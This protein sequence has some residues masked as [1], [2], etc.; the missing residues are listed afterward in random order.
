[1]RLD[2]Y[3][4]SA[5]YGTRSEIKKLI[6]KGLVFVRDNPIKD[7]GYILSD[8]EWSA[9]RI[10]GIDI[11]PPSGVYLMLYKPDG[12][13]TAMKDDRFPVV[14]ELI[15]PEFFKKGLSPV[16]RLDFHTTGLLLFTNDG[17]LSHRLTSPKWHIEKKYR[18]TY[19]GERL[20]QKEVMAFSR[21]ITISES[22]KSPVTFS[23]ANLEILEN[24]TA[25]L[26]L[27]EG[28][29]HQVKRMFA[30]VHR[31]VTSLFREQINNLT[32]KGLKEGESRLLI[33]EEIRELKKAA[34]LEDSGYT[35]K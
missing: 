31:P 15:P 13:L 33:P 11:V 21:G 29:T 7:S 1:M 22:G 34:G 30:S 16:G 9:V 10:Q 4:A 25:H 2:K 12:Y 5:G 23:P 35:K 26:T 28:K 8:E 19:E 3:I 32:L 6:R 27:R 17:L 18:I 20:T 24:H 14:S